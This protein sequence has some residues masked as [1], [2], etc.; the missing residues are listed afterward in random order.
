[1][2]CR[3][4][5]NGTMKLEYNVNIPSDVKLAMDLAKVWKEKGKTQHRLI[6]INKAA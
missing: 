1:M 3:P 5:K 2:Y 4:S 6:P